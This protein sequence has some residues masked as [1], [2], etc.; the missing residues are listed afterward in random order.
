MSRFYAIV[1][2]KKIEGK[3]KKKEE[4]QDTYDDAIASGNSAFLLEE[5]IYKNY[6][7]LFVIF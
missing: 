1:D 6:K 4:A 7:L 2:G 3:I 5:G